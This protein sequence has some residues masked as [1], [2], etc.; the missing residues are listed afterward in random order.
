MLLEEQLAG[1]PEMLA[2][3]RQFELEYHE[4]TAE[5]ELVAAYFAAGDRVGGV[6]AIHIAA[7]QEEQLEAELAEL[8]HEVEQQVV[9]PSTWARDSLNLA[10][11]LS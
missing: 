9:T 10:L 7:A 1:E 5:L 11:G 3:L 8:A 2:Q 6:A 4:F